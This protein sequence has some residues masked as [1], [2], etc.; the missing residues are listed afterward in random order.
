M[1]EFAAFDSL[2][3]EG[4]RSWV[5]EE[6]IHLHDQGIRAGRYGGQRELTCSLRV[7]VYEAYVS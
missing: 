6:I 2:W 3:M 1:I 5:K 4:S 7:M